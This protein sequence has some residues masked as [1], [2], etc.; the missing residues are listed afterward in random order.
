MSS[1]IF[2][3]S[4]RRNWFIFEDKLERMLSPDSPFLDSYSDLGSAEYSVLI[5]FLACRDVSAGERLSC[6]V[7]FVACFITSLI[8]SDGLLVSLALVRKYFFLLSKKEKPEDWGRSG[9]NKA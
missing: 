4:L 5:L 8:Y 6:S 1:S 3:E 9:R 7:L 2:L